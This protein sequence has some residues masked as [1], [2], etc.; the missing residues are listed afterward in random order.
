MM[1]P[2]EIAFR[3]DSK[4]ILKLRERLDRIRRP[5]QG[6]LVADSLDAP[7]SSFVELRANEEDAGAMQEA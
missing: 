4:L 6:L 7:V 3:I 2:P 1:H 5:L